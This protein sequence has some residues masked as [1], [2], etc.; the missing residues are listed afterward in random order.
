MCFMYATVIR[1]VDSVYA[2]ITTLFFHNAHGLYQY[3][4]PTETHLKS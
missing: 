1:W 2:Y 4:H 3:K